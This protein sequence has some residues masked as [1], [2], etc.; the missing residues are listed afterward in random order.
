MVYTTQKRC[1]MNKHL[2]ELIERTL[3]RKKIVLHKGYDSVVFWETCELILICI[4][5][6]LVHALIF[7]KSDQRD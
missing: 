5:T 3:P 1:A 2:I 6:T 4:L 7:N